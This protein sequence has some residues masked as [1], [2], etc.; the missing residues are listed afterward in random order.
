M[1]ALV[2]STKAKKNGMIKLKH[3][4]TNTTY[5]IQYTCTTVTTHDVSTKARIDTQ[6]K[7]ND[8]TMSPM[9]KKY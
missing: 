2:I 6:A 4:D 8:T 9:R 1:Q 7:R 5:Y 3:R